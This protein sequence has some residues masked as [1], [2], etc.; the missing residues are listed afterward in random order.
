[1]QRKCIAP[2]PQMK[3]GG[4]TSPKCVLYDGGV[5]AADLNNID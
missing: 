4:I 1:M 2:S 3:N 5:T